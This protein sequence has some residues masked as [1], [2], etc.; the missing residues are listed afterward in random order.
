MPAQSFKKDILN[1]LR[2][3]ELLRNDIS[4]QEAFRIQDD[5]LK[6]LKQETAA[7][8]RVERIEQ[9]R[10]VAGL[11]VSYASLKHGEKGFA[12]A[13]LWDLA[14]G[15]PKAK[16]LSTGPVR[17][18][19]KPSLLGFREC[20]LLAKAIKNLPR[21]PD[22]I[23]CDGH[24]CIH[25]KRFGEAVQLGMALNIPSM[26]VA[27]NPFIGYG[28]WETMKRTKGNAEPVWA[29]DPNEV[30]R[31]SN[32]LLGYSV[33]LNDA[34]KP[35]FVSA[36]FRLSLDLALALALAAARD[37]RIPEPIYL[38]DKL[39]R[40]MMKKEAQDDGSSPT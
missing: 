40:S 28:R 4:L 22:V 29:K 37:H 9:V 12:C 23:M 1:R 3:E 20:R 32:E 11:D 18:P 14:E 30:S 21:K 25:P 35:V 27:K 36:G 31:E 38:A 5:S 15:A 6:S 16:G 24:G 19:Y 33:S 39:S 7:S 2:N 34:M 17:F 10:F 26:G 8:S 13:L